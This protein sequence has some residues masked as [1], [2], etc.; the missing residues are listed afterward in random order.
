MS[1]DKLVF[2]RTYD[3]PIEK[4]WKAITD[5]NQ[6]KQ[7]YFELDQFR[8]EKGFQFSFYG[9]RDGTKFLH[10]C[11]VLEANPVTRLSYSWRYEGYPGNSVVT[12]DL[13]ATGKH[14]TRLVLTH[15]GLDSLVQ[16]HT[17]FKRDDFEAGWNQIAGESLRNFVEVDNLRAQI[18]INASAAAVWQIILSPN[19]SWAQAFG[20][21]TIAKTNWLE[22]S[23]ISWEDAEGGIGARG[24]IKSSVEN[25]RLE[26]AY[27]DEVEEAP[28]ETLGDYREIFTIQTEGENKLVVTAESGPLQKLYVVKHGDMWN[29]ALEMIKVKAESH[30]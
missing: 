9:E 15:S 5:K 12:F 26:L 25:R 8:A 21:G 28:G 29:K 24:I 6:M 22:G 10:K 3:A 14:R 30:T 16:G 1:S 4:V 20:E 11:E 17:D 18:T 13:S 7:W 19:N 2:E 27:F 23:S